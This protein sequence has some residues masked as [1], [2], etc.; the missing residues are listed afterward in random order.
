VANS[1]S[2]DTKNLLDSFNIR[3]NKSLG[4]HFL[5][6]QAALSRIVE[7]AELSRNDLVL[8][9]GTGIGALT[10]ELCSKAGFVISSEYDK[11][12]IHAAEEYLKGQGNYE[13]VAGDFLKLDLG[14]MLARFKDYK[15]RKVVANLPYY[16]TSPIIE[17][18]I[19]NRSC[20]K[21]MILTIQREVAHRI[22]SKPG[23]KEYGSF[24][25]FVNYYCKPKIVSYIPKSS[26]LPQPDVG[27][28]VIRLDV[29]EKPA[30]KVK[31]EK[32]FFDVMHAAFMQRRKMLKNAIENAKIEGLDR[33]KIEEALA[34]SG[35]DLRRRGETLS[36]E[37]FAKL[38]DHLKD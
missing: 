36:I 15:S 24:T 3:L 21:C 19:D 32:L 27:S 37:E 22:V 11:K 25:V 29:H 31:S 16:I 5:V 9:I 18:L 33:A 7:A 13:I 26:F 2:E 1:L 14:P 12:L 35:I 10:R 17:K 4:Q 34:S 6:D 23:T 8:E 38:A 30:V 20:F 28:A